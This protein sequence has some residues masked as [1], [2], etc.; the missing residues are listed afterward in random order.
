MSPD[1]PPPASVDL[2]SGPA[3]A[4]RMEPQ[5][6][7][8]QAVL[9]GLGKFQ[10]KVFS[11]STLAV[12]SD[13]PST[14]NLNTHTPCRG[15]QF[16]V[17]LPKPRGK[18]VL[19]SRFIPSE[20]QGS[21]TWVFEV[22]QIISVSFSPGL[23]H[24]SEWQHNSCPQSPKRETWHY[25]CL[26]APVGIHPPTPLSSPASPGLV[27]P[28]IPP[29]PNPHGLVQVCTYSSLLISPASFVAPLIPSMPLQSTPFPEATEA[30]L[31]CRSAR[32]L[33]T[34]CHP[35]QCPR[36]RRRNKWR[37]TEG[38]ET[39]GKLLGRA[40]ALSCPLQPPELDPRADHS[41][42]QG[43]HCPFPPPSSGPGLSRRRRIPGWTSG[44]GAGAWA[45]QRGA[46]R[47]RPL[48]QPLA[49]T[50]RV[51]PQPGA[52]CG[53]SPLR[54]RLGSSRR[55]TAVPGGCWQVRAGREKPRL[56]AVSATHSR[57]QPLAATLGAR[58][59]GAQWTRHCSTACWRPTAAWSW[60][61]SWFWTAGGCPCTPRVGE[62]RADPGGAGFLPGALGALGS[63]RSSASRPAAPR[64]PQQPL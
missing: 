64:G 34:P 19:T 36:S 20:T 4:L 33:S 45:G 63:P 54:S 28:E 47:P 7:K 13:L 37:D 42:T 55:S 1:P 62:S 24:F 6:V 18:E 2:S 57:T 46:V 44:P 53:S 43:P 29:H 58:G 26:L 22:L 5:G 40:G 10:I 51:D 56:C 11:S 21:K 3:L 15:N 23:P 25:P 52:F 59:S 61:K 60:P 38:E 31:E 27:F 16:Q 35:L 48:V 12:G 30:F 9:R 41:A 49:A 32:G 14:L 39:R 8:K 50:E 17:V